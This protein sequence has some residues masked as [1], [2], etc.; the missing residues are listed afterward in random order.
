MAN[1][2]QSAFYYN[3]GASALLAYIFGKVTGSD[4]EE[5]AFKYLFCTTWYYPLFLEAYPLL[6]LQI[7]RMDCI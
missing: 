4:I 2:L 1:E 5:N 3:S 7:Q 6:H